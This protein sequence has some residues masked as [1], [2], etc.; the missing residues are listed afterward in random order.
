MV[1]PS[2]NLAD[3]LEAAAKS[4]PPKTYNDSLTIPDPELYPFILQHW[5]ISLH[6]ATLVDYSTTSINKS[7]LPDEAHPALDTIQS[8]LAM[9]VGTIL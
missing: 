8:R 9:G 7:S 2:I 5:A 6:A 1:Q 4:P 3:T